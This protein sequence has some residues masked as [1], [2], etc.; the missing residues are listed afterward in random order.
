ME[1]APRSVSSS[2]LSDDD[3]D[4]GERVSLLAAIRA[5]RT[6]EDG[7]RDAHP[8]ATTSTAD[9]DGAGPSDG[10][11]GP[12]TPRRRLNLRLDAD[13]V[14][15]ISDERAR[16]LA[17][18]VDGLVFATTS[19][20]MELRTP[21]GVQQQRTMEFQVRSPCCETADLLEVA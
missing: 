2:S 13:V 14:A 20:R 17:G 1:P 5:S 12:S 8:P 10:G 4:T 11:A 9:A 18:G 3:R 19:G 15:Q 7:E 6:E 21:T 16:E